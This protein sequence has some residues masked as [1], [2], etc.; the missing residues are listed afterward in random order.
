MMRSSSAPSRVI[1]PY[2]TSLSRVS[3]SRLNFR[4]VSEQPS[5]ASGGA[6]TLTR[7]PSSRRASQI[8]LE[9][10][11]AAPDLPDDLL[12]DVE[13]L[14]AFAEADVRPLDLSA[15]LDEDVLGAVDHDV[16]D[17][18]A[19]QQWLERPVAE[20]VVAD[21]AQHA[22][23]LDHRKGDPAERHDL[24]HDVLHLLA[25]S[26][27]RHSGEQRDVDRLDQRVV[28]LFLRPVERRDLVLRARVELVRLGARA[29]LT[30]RRRF[31]PRGLGRIWRGILH[32]GG[33]QS[34]CRR[35]RGGGGGRRNGGAPG[36]RGR[37]G[38]RRQAGRVFTLASTK[39]AAGR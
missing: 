5:I 22:V 26:L 20:Q 36:A 16:G 25:R 35:G 34:R 38:P 37:C 13:K 31:R 10:V 11:D 28:D 3:L 12:A 4:I 6:M 17:V 29:T 19:R 2:S 27:G 1:E 24:L 33:K 23:L 18:V 9:L 15:D 30:H 7:L 39:H 32:G 21:L 8:G 14:L